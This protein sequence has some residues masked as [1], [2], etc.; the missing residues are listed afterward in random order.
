M[1]AI[2][3][4]ALILIFM[5]VGSA[6]AVETKVETTWDYALVERSL[7]LA[8]RPGDKIVFK[9]SMAN[10][11]DMTRHVEVRTSM[12]PT[13]P[14]YQQWTTSTEKT[15]RFEA[16][17]DKFTAWGMI[18]WGIV[19]PDQDPNSVDSDGGTAYMSL[20]IE[21]RANLSAIGPTIQKKGDVTY[22][23]RVGDRPWNP[24]GNRVTVGLYYANQA[25]P[26]GGPIE[27]PRTMKIEAGAS[28][29]FT[30]PASK[31]PALP[32]GA[33]H[34]MVWIDQR[35]VVPE[36]D[37]R[38]N[39][40]VAILGIQNL[41]IVHAGMR[42]RNLFDV[43]IERGFYGRSLPVT[44][45]AII[46]GKVLKLPPVF[47]GD[48]IAQ[49]NFTRT[50]VTFDLAALGV[51]RFKENARFSVTVK[52]L[53]N[54]HTLTGAIPLPVLLV[55]GID[56]RVGDYSG[57]IPTP[58]PASLSI[59][60]DANRDGM[61][62]LTAADQ[63]ASG[64][65]FPFWTNN[66]ADSDSGAFGEDGEPASSQPD[67][68]D[69][70]LKSVRDLEDLFPVRL[71]LPPELRKLL[72]GG[73]NL[74]LETTGLEVNVFK[75]NRQ[76]DPFRYLTTD[77]THQTGKYFPQHPSYEAGGQQR[78][79]FEALEKTSLHSY[80]TEEDFDRGAVVVLVEGKA[81]GAGEMHLSLRATGKPETRGSSIFIRFY[82]VKEMYQRAVAPDYTFT[83]GTR[84]DDLS[85]EPDIRKAPGDV[86]MA[87]AAWQPL[88]PEHTVIFVH[89]WNMTEPDKDS[90]GDT[91]FKRLWWAGYRGR[92]IAFRWNCLVGTPWDWPNG[93]DGH[94]TFNSSEYLAWKYAGLFKSFI[95]TRT[96]G[97]VH[98]AAHSQGNILV[99]EALRLGLTAKTYV[100]MQAAAPSVSYRLDAAANDD[101]VAREN[102]QRTFDANQQQ[103]IDAGY[104]GW[105]LG[106]G[107]NAG[108]VVNFFNPR[109]YAL[110]LWFSNQ[111]LNKIA[112]YVPLFGSY[113][114]YT[115]IPEKALGEKHSVLRITPYPGTL[116]PSVKFVR[117]V[118]DPYEVMSFIA[119]PTTLAA[120][121]TAGLAGSEIAAEVN[122][123]AD[124]QFGDDRHEHSGQ[125]NYPVQRVL[126]FYNR[127]LQEC[128]VP[129]VASPLTSLTRIGAQVAAATS[130]AAS[131]SAATTSPYGARFGGN[132]SFPKLETYL[133]KTFA[134]LFDTI[135]ESDGYQYL[136]QPTFIPT[137]RGTV[138]RPYYPTLHTLKLPTEG[139]DRNTIG[140]KDGGRHL[141]A[142]LQTLYDYTWAERINVV[143]HGKGCLL[144]RAMLTPEIGPGTPL[145]VNKCIMI[146]G[147]HLGT[148][149]A[150]PSLLN[151]SLSD[152]ALQTTFARAF[153][154]SEA[155]FATMV[156]NYGS[157]A[158]RSLSPV[159]PYARRA[160]SKKFTVGDDRNDE[161][162]WLNGMTSERVEMANRSKV[163]YF[164]LYSDKPSTGSGS[165]REAGTLR[166][167]QY[168]EGATDGNPRF[169]RGPGDNF[170][171]VFSQIGRQYDPNVRKAPNR[172]IPA[173][174]KNVS[175]KQIK[176]VRI[177]S[178]HVSTMGNADT[179]LKIWGIIWDRLPSKFLQDFNQ[180][181]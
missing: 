141:N 13:P 64:N 76:D 106:I 136:L 93:H 66:D 134:N 147:P 117:T 54:E 160:G 155:R 19:W 98:I 59:A 140:L 143:A 97:N 103:A 170:V 70:K 62:S 119:R 111:G 84:G 152:P 145:K 11:W 21:P 112:Q 6:E 142:Q 130:A 78:W 172:P 1:T 39:R 61:I 90:F 56:P 114:G 168:P 113:F 144:A 81:A 132:G 4:L 102:V 108:R 87:D 137:D 100:L 150:A 47:L 89:G 164:F 35:D 15:M 36:S 23:Y 85:Q 3:M 32:P 63:T 125:F 65:P 175:G 88:Q 48:E 52:A 57:I 173:F 153:G 92:F 46:A 167:V 169:A 94:L 9:F 177:G 176:Y 50:P 122:L 139:P 165:K 131:V 41:K 26:I 127:L 179:H 25:G 109:D 10:G 73:Y 156:E 129:V 2:P 158:F 18:S 163:K 58:N 96:G 68:S 154:M 128:G 101:L 53:Q 69:L 28:E 38:D 5:C 99:S 82:D 30:V 75:A 7:S 71:S 17:S 159:W 120:G 95:Q 171:P 24:R 118:T 60:V 135:A 67:N 80:L 149:A 157:L 91:M 40:A 104:R 37:E 151:G 166:T 14:G 34:Y 51:P 31:M 148:M 126:P 161:L 115:F 29:T 42:S 123:A 16:N 74:A 162:K 116:P 12:D 49:G 181:K 86:S 110:N 8:V 174:Q 146:E 55:P 44:V 27:T 178:D 79:Y 45:S 72:N 22:G 20:A 180:L 133:K 43:H 105:F 107:R 121:A 33:T 124:F 77:A 83:D 138:D